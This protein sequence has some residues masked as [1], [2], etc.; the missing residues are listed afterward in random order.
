MERIVVVGTS[1]SGKTTLARCLAKRL[2]I[3]H[4]ELDA[5]Y[6]KPNWVGSP[7]DVFRQCVKEA[8]SGKRWVVDGNYSKTRD[9]VW[10]RADTIV[11]LD[12][13]LWILLWRIF[14]RGI[15]RSITRENLW[16]TGNRETLYRHFFTHDSMILWVLKTYR[17]RRREYP[18]LFTQPEYAHLRVVKLRSRRE[19]EYWV[20]NV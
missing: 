1:G 7:T 12:Y 17:K 5:L 20:E 8:V 4:I 13:P 16:G 3:P 9:I 2:D 6:W 11:W 14:K 15:R 10:V 19:T 18:I